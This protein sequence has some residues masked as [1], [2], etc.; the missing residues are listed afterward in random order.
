[1]DYNHIWLNLLPKVDRPFFYIFLWM[2]ATFGYKQKNPEKKTLYCIAL[3]TVGLSKKARG[4]SRRRRRGWRWGRWGPGGR[5]VTQEADG[6]AGAH[7]GGREAMLTKLHTQSSFPFPCKLFPSVEKRQSRQ[8]AR[9]GMSSWTER[10]CFFYGRS[11][12]AIFKV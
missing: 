8:Q 3:G 9:T 11:C 10:F 7:S 4:S 2:I 1:M 5:T 12:R 6:S